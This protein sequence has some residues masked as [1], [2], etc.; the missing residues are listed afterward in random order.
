MI[1]IPC[2][3]LWE[4]LVL[5]GYYFKSQDRKSVGLSTPGVEHSVI[6]C[7][8]DPCPTHCT[9]AT[10][11]VYLLY[12]IIGQYLSRSVVQLSSLAMTVRAID[13][14][15]LCAT[16]WEKST[17]KNL[18]GS[19]EWV[20]LYARTMSIVS[21]TKDLVW[22]KLKLKVKHRQICLTCPY[23]GRNQGEPHLQ[24]SI[25]CWHPMCRDKA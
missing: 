10:P 14:I 22:N 17:K 3:T 21:R 7:L 5:V 8:R 25:F 11:Y 13:S 19:C 12:R 23:T 2:D 24:Y 18:G 1:S 4:T 16:L 9:T 15:C 6:S 20:P